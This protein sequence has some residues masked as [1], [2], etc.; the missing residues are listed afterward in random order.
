MFRGKGKSLFL[1]LRKVPCFQTINQ[2]MSWRR[3]QAY[4]KLKRTTYII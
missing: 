1:G 3:M 4:V 2:I